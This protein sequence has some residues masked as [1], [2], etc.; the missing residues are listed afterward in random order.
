LQYFPIFLTGSELSAIVIGGGEVAARKIELLLKSTRHITIMAKVISP[1]VENLIAEHQLTRLPHNYR[2]GFLSDMTLVIAATN[3]TEVNAE[4]AAEANH[5]N[6]LV[7]VVDEPQLCTYIT[8]AI[9][10]RAPMLIALS[11]SGR[12]PILLRMLRERIEK[13]LP[14]QYGKLAEF[15]FKFRDL[16]KEKINSLVQRRLFWEEILRGDVGEKVLNGQQSIAEVEFRKQLA[17][18]DVSARGKLSFIYIKSGD[19]DDLTLKAHRCCQFTETVFFQKNIGFNLLEYVR[20][21]AEKVDYTD[22]PLDKTLRMALG[23]AEK[24]RKVVFL[25]YQETNKLSDALS[26]LLLSQAQKDLIEYYTC[27][28]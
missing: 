24:E 7:N 22:E 9:I 3:S 20:R 16:V 8:P 2:A 27:G 23:E 18:G 21:D 13:Q 25:F 4:V 10:D 14:S 15:S 6:I 17:K 1:R 11:S 12:A 19:P 5:L 26:E 28:H